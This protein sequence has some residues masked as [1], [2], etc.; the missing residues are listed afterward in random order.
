M[1]NIRRRGIFWGL[2][3]RLEEVLIFAMIVLASW[4]AWRNWPTKSNFSSKKD[5]FELRLSILT[6]LGALAVFGLGLW[7]YIRAD[8]WKRTEFLANE[9]KTFFSDPDIRNVLAMC[10]YDPRRV[11]LFHLETLRMNEFPV[12]SKRLQV[13]ALIPDSLMPQM[14]EKFSSRELRIRDSF[15]KFLDTLDRFG[16]DIE[17]NLYSSDDLDPYFGYWFLRILALSTP[18]KNTMKAVDGALWTGALICF[19]E[20]YRY[21]RVS[22]MFQHFLRRSG[23]EISARDILTNA[24]IS[25]KR[26]QK[27]SLDSHNEAIAKEADAALSHLELIGSLLKPKSMK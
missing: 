8:R 12:V 24:S 20:Y 18:K 9:M 26:I 16:A 21:T 17:R 2:K 22:E 27:E 14:K 11:N 19:I 13:N 1:K 6:S 10:D 15:E 4:F 3:V 7:Q 25:I 5:L 23:S